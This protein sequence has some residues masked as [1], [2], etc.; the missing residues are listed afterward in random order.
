MEVVNAF[1]C[2]AAIIDGAGKVSVLGIF[3]NIST[4][5]FPTT[6]AQMTLVA[7]IEGQ[8]KDVGQ[9]NLIIDFVDKDGEQFLP[10]LEGIFELTSSKINHSLILNLQGVLFPHPGI[11]Y[12][13]ISVDDRCLRSMSLKFNQVSNVSH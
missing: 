5:E 12:A 1:F 3:T 2:D 8:P 6:H 4:G 9:H 13:N 11:Y 10:K 7:I